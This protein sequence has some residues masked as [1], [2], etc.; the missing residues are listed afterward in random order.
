MVS[1][2]QRSQYRDLD[3][4]FF[5]NLTPDARFKRFAFFPLSP[6]K[7]PISTQMHVGFPAG[8]QIPSP[9]FNDGS[10]DLNNRLVHQRKTLRHGIRLAEVPHGAIQAVG[11]ARRT[12]DRAKIHQGLIKVIALPL[13]DQGF[14][15]GPQF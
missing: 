10:R 2:D 4:Q 13:G 12:R 6:G 5:K 3:A 14:R 7:L 15:H 8:N 11:I 1:H 9:A